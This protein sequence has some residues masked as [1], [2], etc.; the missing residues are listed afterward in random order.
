MAPVSGARRPRGQTNSGLSEPQLKAALADWSDAVQAA[1]R[2]QGLSV[3]RLADETGIGR[4]RLH[5]WLNGTNAPNPWALSAIAQVIA[6]PVTEQM[7]ALGWLPNDAQISLPAAV[8]Q[9][10]L[11]LTVQRIRQAVDELAM[12]EEHPAAL[13]SLA[14]LVPSNRTAPDTE[15]WQA[16]LAAAPTGDVYRFNAGLYAE[17]DLRAGVEPLS[18]EDLEARFDDYVTTAPAS[19]ARRTSD[20]A[21]VDAIKRERIELHGRLLG[22][23]SARWGTWVGEGGSRWRSLSVT[24]RQR[25]HLFLPFDHRRN[26]AATAAP[27]VL[28]DPDGRTLRNVAFLG[29]PHSQ[30]SLAAAFVS[31]ALGWAFTN[32]AQTTN[33]IYGAR[34]RRQ[35]IDTAHITTIALNMM[36]SHQLGARNTVWELHRPDVLAEPELLTALAQSHEPFV[37]YVRP[38]GALMSLW[39]ERQVD[40]LG[41][42]GLEPALRNRAAFMAETSR[43]LEDA[44][45]ARPPYTYVAFQLTPDEDHLIESSAGGL[46]PPEL[47]DWALRIAWSVLVKLT[48]SADAA[49]SILDP[50]SL[51]A[52]FA[53]RL[54]ADPLLA[55]SELC[56]VE[57]R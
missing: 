19:L 22:E 43:H 7:Q 5:G 48:G 57:L 9:L 38:S 42:E 11:R 24:N 40:N 36:R 33:E 25:T 44:L 37:V 29:V 3:S 35:R 14:L 12:L 34:N 39:E 56:E 1:A 23:P 13:V 53:P 26:R 52:K 10:D 15:R 30:A 51:M 20:P 54:A 21:D 16:H 50:T 27:A 18:W 49:A 41:F 17:F 4:T 8:D 2:A 55:G 46:E 6:V 32:V 47:S 31:R 28:S 45:R